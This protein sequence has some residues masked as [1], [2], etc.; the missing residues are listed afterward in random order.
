MLDD[1]CQHA[2]I[3]IIDNDERDIR[4]LERVLNGGHYEV[5]ATT[6]PKD[7]LPLYAELE[8]DLIFLGLHMSS[9]DGL[10]VIAALKPWIPAADYV[11]IVVLTSN[12]DSEL[13]E[14]A[15]SRG[16]HDCLAKPVDP[17]ETRTRVRNLLN[18]RCLHNQLREYA[19]G[20]EQRVVERTR[21]LEESRI[22]ILE[23]LARAAEYRDDVTGEHARRVGWLAGRIGHA[24]G[25]DQEAV[26]LLDRAATLHDLGKIG[27]PDAILLKPGRLDQQEIGTVQAHTTIGA[28]ILSGSTE[29]LLKLAADIAETHHERWDGAGYPCGMSGE[30]I[31]LVG[32]IVAV[33]DVFD[34][35]THRRPYKHA[36]PMD[37]A[38]AEIRAQAGRQ[39]DPTAVKGLLHV[40]KR[41]GLDAWRNAGITR[42]GNVAARSTRNGGNGTREY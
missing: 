26:A 34:A 36:W 18:T 40:L 38:L 6:S 5:Y 8:P 30:A 15:L 16:A 22:A 33:A 32:R 37:R 14:R 29:P 9:M 35:L 27:V 23:R 42:P 39:L 31:P 28:R 41:E 25:Y 21:D 3:L 4:Q 10:E 11:P 24:L 17:L 20:L 19:L 2:R 13:K 12:G 1:V 7:A